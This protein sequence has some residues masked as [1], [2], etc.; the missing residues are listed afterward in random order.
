MLAFTGALG[1]GLLRS[2]T[3]SGMRGAETFRLVET[4]GID[5][6]P[7]VGLISTLLGLIIAFLGAL[8][9]S[10]TARTSTSPT[11]WRSRWCASSG[12]S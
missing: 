5:A 2:L 4:S 12:R 11:V 6:V 8:Q 7:I 10:A 3:G 9:L 1:I